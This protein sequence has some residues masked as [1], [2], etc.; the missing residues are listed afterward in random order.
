M[1][2]PLLWMRRRMEIARHAPRRRQLEE[3]LTRFWGQSTVLVSGSIKRGY[4]ETYHVFCGG[5]RVAVARVTNRHIS[6]V[7]RPDPGSPVVP[8]EPQDRLER[9]WLVYQQLFPVGLSPQPLWRTSDAIVCGW[10]DW[11]R[12][13]ETVRRSSSQFW[14][15]MDTILPSIRRMHQCGVTHLDLNPGNILTEPDSGRVAFI[16]FEFGPLPGIS[17]SQQQAYDYL[18]LIDECLRP[19]RGGRQL[20]AETARLVGLLQGCV[21]DEIRD[22]DTVPLQGKLRRLMSQSTLVRQLQAVFRK[23]GNTPRPA[24]RCEP[25]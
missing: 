15:R 23:L 8:L 6:Q 17:E 4:D 9:E 18:R 14:T 16:D 10:L 12:V 21:D 5:T 20:L 19:R 24:V 2:S 1:L 7:R 3:D 25:G 22:V 11:P 13:S